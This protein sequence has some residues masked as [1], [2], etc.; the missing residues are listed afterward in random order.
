MLFEPTETFTVTLSNPAPAGLS[1]GDGTGTGS[2]ADND[3]PVGLSIG[4]RTLNEGNTG[5]RTASFTV[6]LSS[7]SLAPVTVDFGTADGSA[8]AG[9][10]HTASSG[11]V[12]I[13]AG[14]RSATVVITIIGDRLR[15]P[16]ETFTV[17]LSDPSGATIAD[18]QGLGTIRNDDRR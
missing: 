12:T 14:R 7:A 15:E 2:I 1:I 3:K 18:G 16:N 4:D 11:T 17:T 13:A 10:D 5:T 9:S 6:T 8:V